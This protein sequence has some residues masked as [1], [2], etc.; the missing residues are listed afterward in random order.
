MSRFVTFRRKLNLFVALNRAESVIKPKP[1]STLQHTMVV[2]CSTLL[3]CGHCADIN[4]WKCKT[5]LRSLFEGIVLRM[6]ITA[7]KTIR[8]L[9]DQFKTRMRRG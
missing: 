3:F 4:V 7:K 5:I 1:I 6:E 8:S 9:C 2:R